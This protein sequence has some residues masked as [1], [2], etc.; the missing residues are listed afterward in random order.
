M[1]RMRTRDIIIGA[2]VLV[3]LI[4][5]VLIIKRARNRSAVLPTSTPTIQERVQK[6]FNGL[7]IPADRENADL[8]DVTGGQGIGVASRKYSGGTY[9]LTII[10]NLPDPKSGYFYQGWIIR[11]SVGDSNFSYIS[12]GKLRLAKGGYL[13]DFTA[14]KD[15]SDYKKVAVTLEKADDA[16][17]EG[18]VLE[19]SF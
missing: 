10:A 7:V 12:A 14:T 3:V 4:S 1:A 16:T 19:G 13:T 18:N 11:G 5:G 15:Y 6:T 9:S 2:I 17:P 8:V